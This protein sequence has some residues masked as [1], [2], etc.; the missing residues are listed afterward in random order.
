MKSKSGEFVYDDAIW[1]LFTLQMLQFV[2]VHADLT[3]AQ[4]PERRAPRNQTLRRY[5][6]VYLYCSTPKRW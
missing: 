5:S 2:V 4:A 1:V 3:A 6:Y